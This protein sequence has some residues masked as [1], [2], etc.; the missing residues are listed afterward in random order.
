MLTHTMHYGSGVFEGIRAYPSSRDSAVFRSAT[1]S[2]GCSHRPRSSD[3]RA[4]HRGR[5]GRGGHAPWCGSTAW[6]MA[7]TSVPCVPRVRQMGLDPLPCPVNV[8]VAAWPWGTYLGDEGIANGVSCK[9]SSWRA[10]RPQRRADRGQGTGMYANSSLA[11]VEA[12]NA[13]YDKAI[14]LAPNGDVSECT[15]KNSSSCATVSS[16][17]LRRRTPERSTASPQDTVGDHR[18]RP[19]LRGPTRAHHP[20]GPL[21]GRRGLPHRDSGRGGPDPG[22]RRPSRRFRTPGPDHQGDP[23]DV[24]RHRPG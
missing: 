7:A 10:A 16:S 21:P 2:A 23:A 5:A 20:H 6:T 17:P 12:L 1:T 3:R 19:R 4:L 8:S 18:P 15:G 22:R 11:K 13:G 9:I 24:L 14:L